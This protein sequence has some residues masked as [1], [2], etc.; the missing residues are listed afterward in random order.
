MPMQWNNFKEG[1]AI[2]EL[3]KQPGVSQLVKYSAGGGDFNPLHHDYNFPQS[4]AIGSI[5]VHGRFKYASLGE[6]VS[7]WLDHGGRIVKLGCQYRGMDL[8]DKEMTLGGTVK[9][10]W[11]EDGKKLAELELYVNNEAGKNTTPGS[12]IVRFD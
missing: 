6:L 12:A 5:I 3:K 9:R 7:G 10:K 8:P 1:D 11:E 4:K 2:P